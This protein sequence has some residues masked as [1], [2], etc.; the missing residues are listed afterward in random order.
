MRDTD[1]EIREIRTEIIESRGLVIKTNNLTNSLAA[2]IKSIAKRQASYE[3]RFTW[4][5]AVAYVLFATLSFVGLKLWSDVRINEIESEQE[6]LREEVSELRKDLAEETRRTQQ[7]EQAEARAAAFYTM[8]RRKQRT[9]VVEGYEEIR[10]QQLSTAERAFFK[11]AHD[12]FRQELSVQ[13][14]QKG[15]GLM[16]TGRFA[17]AAESFQEAERLD[18]DAPHMPAV[19]YELARAM[20][21][22]GRHGEASILAKEVLEQTRDKE[23]QP[24]AA[25]L[26]ARCADDLGNIDDAR[27][28]LR[29][30]LRRWPR[31]ALVPDA[32]RFL[33][34]LNLKLWKRK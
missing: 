24:D 5:S 2:D 14:Y 13:A 22:L 3:R 18:D 4:N 26:L 29:T 9:E 33:G 20:R 15:L 16:R 31:S 6:G 28:A 19:H 30:L 10:Q 21:K 12:H 27:N 25:M 23:L 8:V 32:R 11:D 1:D 17:E 34:E 7:R